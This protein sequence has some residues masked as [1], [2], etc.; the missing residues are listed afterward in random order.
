M[1]KKING[2]VNKIEMALGR[3]KLI[4]LPRYAQI[5]PTNRCNEKCV[6]CPRNESDYDVLLGKMSLEQFKDILRQIPT[7]TDFQINGLGEPLLHQDIFE[8]IRYAADKGINIS[9]NSNVVIVKTALITPEVFGYT[10]FQ[11]FSKCE[12]VRRCIGRK[13][14]A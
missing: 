6:F 11:P 10:F 5:E 2:I 1:I 12:A 13:S 8:M 9:M 3:T 4:S 7:L 14:F